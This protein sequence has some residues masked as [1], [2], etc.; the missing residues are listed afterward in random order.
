MIPESALKD[1]LSADLENQDR[2]LLCMAVTPVRSRQV[3][4]IRGAA[5]KH[6][7]RAAKKIN[8][9]AVLA[10][11]PSLAVRTADGWELTATGSSHVAQVAGPL[12]GSPIPKVASSLRAHLS[13]VKSADVQQ[14]LTEAIVCFETRQHRAAVVLSWVGAVAILQDFVVSNSLGAF[15]AEALRR[16]GKWKAAS[17]SDELGR[18]KEGDFLDILESI[19]LIGKNVKQELKKCLQ[20]RNGCG[21][22]NSLQVAEHKVSAHIEDLVLNVFAKFP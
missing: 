9:S 14:F 8:I 22:P 1:L 16:D 15:N 19:S 6:G 2:L 5:V 17:T 21:H 7:W 10:R 13:K 20:L 4:E 12:L 11:F 3:K 18:L